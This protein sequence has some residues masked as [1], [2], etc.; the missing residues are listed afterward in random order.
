M[1]IY[2]RPVVKMS[3]AVAKLWVHA[4]NGVNLI[5]EE[6]QERA[7]AEEAIGAEPRSTML[8]AFFD[9]CANPETPADILREGYVAGPLA[10]ELRYEDFPRYYRWDRA[11]RKWIRRKV[12]VD[13]EEFVARLGSVNP[14]NS[15]L[16][17]IRIL[18]QNTAGELVGVVC[19]GTA[20]INCFI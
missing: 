7:A 18:L 17:A 10:N 19:L 15:E 13:S 14:R 20:L 9:R 1:R 2:G 11:S 5:F 6:G 16:T 12:D 3:H 4:P 8:T